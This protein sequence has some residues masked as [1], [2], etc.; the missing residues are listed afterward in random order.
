VLCQEHYFKI[1]AKVFPDYYSAHE[2]RVSVEKV[3]LLFEVLVQ[4]KRVLFLQTPYNF[5]RSIIVPEV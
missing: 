4:L 2:Y 3:P 5:T 1:L